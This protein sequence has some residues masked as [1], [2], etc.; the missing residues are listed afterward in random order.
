MK[1]MTTCNVVKVER[2]GEKGLGMQLTIAGLTEEEAKWLGDKLH[3]PMLDWL[4]ELH[5]NRGTSASYVDVNALENTTQLL[6]KGDKK[7]AN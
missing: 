7:N 3:Q 6:F 5:R 1:I 2:H 4:D